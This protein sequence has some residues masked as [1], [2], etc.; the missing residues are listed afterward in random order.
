MRYVQSCISTKARSNRPNLAGYYRAYYQRSS[1][2][3]STWNR[4]KTGCRGKSIPLCSRCEVFLPH[5]RKDRHCQNFQQTYWRPLKIWLRLLWQSWRLTEAPLRS[6][7]IIW[8]IRKD[9]MD[10]V[11]RDQNFA[12][13][14]PHFTV[15]SFQSNSQKS[16]SPRLSC[17]STTRYSLSNMKVPKRLQIK[18]LSHK[19]SCQCYKRA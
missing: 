10:R 16:K 12:N 18:L 3:L 1:R 14:G 7:R 4:R 15:Q 5:N 2:A 8:T 6:S 19:P 17:L 13:A 9:L 11:L